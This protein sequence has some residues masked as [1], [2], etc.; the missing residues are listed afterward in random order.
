LLAIGLFSSF[1]ICLII[2]YPV[3]WL[4]GGLGIIFTAI[5]VLSDNYLDTFIGL[6]WGYSS[7]MVARIYEVMNN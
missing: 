2:G 3:A 1:T 5:S 7:I 4:M 6:D